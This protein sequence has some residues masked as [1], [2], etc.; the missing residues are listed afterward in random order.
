ME[1]LQIP[2]MY[3]ASLDVSANGVWGRRYEKT[4]F[5]VRIVNPFAPSNPPF[6]RPACYRKHKREK[7]ARNWTCNLH[8]TIVLSANGGMGKE[9]TII[10][11]IFID[12]RLASVLAQKWDYPYNTTLFG[13]NADWTFPFKINY[14]SHTRSMTF[15]ARTCITESHIP[16][17][18]IDLGI[19]HWITYF[20][21][22]YSPGH[23]LFNS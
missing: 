13:Y 22:F 20:H 18:L 16:A 1:P 11:I 17:T 9:A 21:L 15:S 10:Y 19:W 4:F 3:I 8:S 5:D 6:P 14:T 12:K 23:W 2:K 7:R